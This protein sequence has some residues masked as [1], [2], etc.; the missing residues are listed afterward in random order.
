MHHSN[1][2]LCPRMNTYQLYGFDLQWS[3][4]MSEMNNN[5]YILADF[6]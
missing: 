1:A 5:P 4:A 2:H 3:E 6:D